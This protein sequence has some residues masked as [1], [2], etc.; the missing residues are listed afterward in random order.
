MLA[1][2]F[3]TE[4]EAKDIL[5]AMTQRRTQSIDG[6]TAHEGLL[7]KAAVVV[8]IIGMG[9]ELSSRGTTAILK[10]YEVGQV[11]LA[12]FAGGLSA[13][14]KRGQIIIVQDYSSEALINYLRLLPGFDI[15]KVYPSATVVSS[16]EQKQAIGREFNCQIVDMETDAVARAVI[17]FCLD[18]LSIR[19][20]SDLATEDI[21]SDVLSQGYNTHTGKTSPLRLLTH[22]AF[23]RNRIKAFK[24]FLAPLP[25]VR[26]KLSAFVMQVVKELEAPE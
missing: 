24:E 17:P 1:L 6:T 12:G 16:A 18:F 3:P 11:I 9:P 19:A 14:M 20:V 23:N 26:Q 7:G 22:L 15:A 2:L 10:Q 8:G 4:Y 25:E 5:G 13:Q 21:P